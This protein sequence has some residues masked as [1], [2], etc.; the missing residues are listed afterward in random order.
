MRKYNGVLRLSDG[1]YARGWSATAMAYSNHW[2]STDQVPLELIADGL[3]NAEIAAKLFLSV[4][5]VDS[6][7]KNM[8]TKFK[9]KNTAALVKYAMT[10]KLI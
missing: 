4:T 9:V 7:R 8:L 1:D 2:T 10:E 6:H 3:T 5:T